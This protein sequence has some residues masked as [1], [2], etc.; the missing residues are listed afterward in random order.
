MLTDRYYYNRLSSAEKTLYSSIYGAIVSL[1]ASVILPGRITMPTLSK[2]I[3]AMSN[4]N[5]HLYYFNQTELKCQ[6]TSTSTTVF[7]QYFFT[8]SEIQKINKQVE[9]AVNTIISKL[10]LEK[11]ADE[12]EREK[13][14]HDVFAGKISYDYDAVTTKDNR[15]FAT[16][17]SIVGVFIDK[18]AVCDG[19]AKATKIL[20]NAANINCIVVTGKSLLE[21]REGH[22]WNIVRINNSAYHLDVTWDVA[23]STTKLTTYD[24]FNLTD[25]AIMKDHSEFTGMPACINTEANYYFANKLCF[26]SI[27]AAKKYVTQAATKGIRHINLLWNGNPDL[28]SQTTCELV[29]QAIETASLDGYN[30]TAKYWTNDMQK[31]ISILVYVRV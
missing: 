2:L 26:N 18:K 29:K 28:F 8:A 24:Y 11:V 13:R 20:L 3:S 17:H 12:L 6:T 14:V 19:I 10:S 15:H 22:A 21:Q 31:T 27:E 7:L 4:D 25:E 16:A 9:T 5:P 1:Q 30:W 23:N